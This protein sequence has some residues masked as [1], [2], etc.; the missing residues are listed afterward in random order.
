MES[1]IFSRFMNKEQAG[2]LSSLAETRIF[3]VPVIYLGK[4]QTLC[5]IGEEMSGSVAEI[6]E[7]AKL[8]LTSGLLPFS[9]L[10]VIKERFL[11][12][13][14]EAQSNSMMYFDF[15]RIVYCGVD[16]SRKKI[17]AFNYHET[18]GKERFLYFTHAFL[19]SNRS[20]AKKLAFAVSEFFNCNI[21]L[22]VTENK[23]HEKPVLQSA[24]FNCESSQEVS[25]KRLS[26]PPRLKTTS[27]CGTTQATPDE[28]SLAHS[29]EKQSLLDIG[30]LKRESIFQNE[31]SKKYE[32]GE[33]DSI[34]SGTTSENED[35]CHPGDP[36]YTDQQTRLLYQKPFHYKK[37]LINEVET[38][39]SQQDCNLMLFESFV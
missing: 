12:S 31:Q 29:I 17:F 22:P 10:E 34:Y 6:Y 1:R 26:S 2:R 23:Q 7:N 37:Q 32:V 27:K 19:C 3:N 39:P 21:A 5:P 4:V 14:Q 25:V 36:D 16:R 33:N 18:K 24:K 15:K 35:W 38:K 20:T 9:T 28:S 30:C 11:L 8:N 13:L